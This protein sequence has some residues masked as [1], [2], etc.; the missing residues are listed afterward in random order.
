MKQIKI[1]HHLWIQKIT[2]L[3]LSMGLL[4]ASTTC[5]AG[6]FSLQEAEQVALT[7][8]PG[9]LSQHWQS[10]AFSEQ[11]VA[12]GQNMD[13]KLL[14]G[15]V[16]LPTDTFAFDQ[17]PMTQFT[18]GYQ[19]QF[20]PGDTRALKQQKAQKQA[21]LMQTKM[22]SR[23][24]TILRDVRQTYLE[25]LYWEQAKNTILKNKHLFV[26]LLD[27]VQSLFSIGRNNQQDLI[28]AQ[29]E[30]SRLDDRLSKI[31]QQINMQRSKLSRWVGTENSLKPLQ[32]EFPEL[33]E[34]VLEA[35]FDSLSERFLDHPQVLEVDRQLE[36]TRKDSQLVD[37]SLKPGWGLTVSYGYREDAPNGMQR[38]DFLSAVVG[39]D[40]PLFSAQR[41]DKK[42]LSKEY[43]YQ[44]LK[45]KRLELIRQLVAELQQEITNESI[46]QQRHALYRKLLLPQARQQS[47]AS[48]L[49]Y[50]SDK[51]RFSDVMRAYVDD[52]NAN[53]DERRITI[54]ISQSKA[55]ILYFVSGLTDSPEPGSFGGY[56]DE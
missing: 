24:I 46:L 42:R 54:D 26:Q 6:S 20:P 44:S 25:I 27:I 37:E 28:R 30:L 52:L 5:I 23:S 33:A 12:D 34:V 55:K 56:R 50:Q 51:G 21:E 2:V 31:E 53:L 38:A 19:Q 48:L 43:E 36:L 7:E 39:I 8:E 14:L 17:E 18:I 3:L 41:Q 49:A 32:K 15:V 4:G 16:N 13:P 45:S 1:I 40:L 29:L 47:Q 10:K 35:D 9:L 11:A 22:S